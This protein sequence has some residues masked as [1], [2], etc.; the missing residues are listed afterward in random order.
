MSSAAEK[1]EIWQVR[2]METQLE[3]K[4][5]WFWIKL[6]FQREE[7]KKTWGHG[8]ETEGE[9]GTRDSGNE[10]AARRREENLET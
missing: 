10:Y 1:P 6:I 9:N 3:T 2:D 7:T 5:K 8:N 4:R